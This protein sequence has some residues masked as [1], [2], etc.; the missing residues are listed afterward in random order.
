MIRKARILV[1]LLLTICLVA[2]AVPAGAA[3]GRKMTTPVPAVTDT[4]APTASPTP[5]PSPTPMPA[6]TAEPTPTPEATVDPTPTPEATVDPTP[7]PTQMVV[8]GSVI[9]VDGEA[10]KAET[11]GQLTEPEETAV[12]EEQAEQPGENANQAPQGNNRV[13]TFEI[14][15]PAEQEL[16]AEGSYEYALHTR[17]EGY[18]P[19]SVLISGIIYLPAGVEIEKAVVAVPG[20]NAHEIPRNE[21]LRTKNAFEP[22]SVAWLRFEPDRERSGFAILVDM[23]EDHLP[24]GPAEVS[25]TLT[26]DQDMTLNTTVNI[27]EK[28]GRFFDVTRAIRGQ[29][30]VLNDMGEQVDA[31]QRRLSELGYLKAEEVTGT[32]DTR[33]MKAANELLAKHNLA[34]NNEYLD[35]EAIGL[36]ESGEAKAKSTGFFDQV[37]DFFKGTVHLL[38]RDI[39]I[40]MLTAAGAALLLLILLIILL[41]TGKKRRAKRKERKAAAAR[42]L[43]GQQAFITSP[44]NAAEESAADTAAKILTIGDE[45]T[46]DLNETTT[47][48]IVYNEDEPT[49]DLNETAFTVKFR[50]IYADRYMDKDILIREGEQAVIGRAEDAQIRTNPEDTSVSHRHGSFSITGG[51][52]NYTDTSRN[53]TRYNG[54]RTLYKGESASIPFNTKAQLE[55]GAHKVLVFAVKQ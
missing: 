21:I 40:W 35:T 16:F 32:C 13:D 17:P 24:D 53:G 49:T 45:P 18:D 27:Q 12:P 29:C 47:G 25:V 30:L 10:N 22:D 51:T 20:G 55:I 4:P 42:D 44:D 19:A 26:T 39:P 5:T 41:I 7:E 2:G 34:Q 8:E 36:I 15:L 31:L 50:L 38:D 28:Q 43:S 46:M 33:T 37:L 1:C 54:Q 23:T 48:G 14:N 6:V 11:S 9:A 3:G 52:L